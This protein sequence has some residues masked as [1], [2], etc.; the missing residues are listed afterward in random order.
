M[1][2]EGSHI[3]IAL[4]SVA[5]RGH[6]LN[7]PECVLAHRSGHLFA[8]D[9]SGAGG[10]AV[11]APDG[12]V[13]HL[14]AR[15]APEP[16]K[17]NGIALE[18]GGSFLIAHLGDTRGGVYRLHPDGR[19]EEV[20]SAVDGV[21]LP[22][23]NFVHLDPAGRLWIT[24]S[25]RQQPRHAAARRDVADGFIVLVPPGGAPR[26]VADGL[27]YTNEC[28]VSP[29]GRSLFVNET[30]SKRLSRYAITGEASLG[31]RETVATFGEG[32]FPDGLVPDMEGGLW[33]TSIV[34]NRVIRLAPDGTAHTLLE[35]CDPAAVAETE[36]IFE[37]GALSSARLGIR[38]GRV[39]ADISSL[40]FGGPDLRT[41]YLGCLKGEAIGTI[42][43][44]VAGVAP[45]HWQ[46]DLTPLADV[47]LVDAA[48]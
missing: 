2:K 41:G 18:P 4:S 23:S 31:P 20:V 12:T 39:L 10:V 30:F 25:T 7:R 13:R 22:P 36:A 37:R 8:A 34:S 11:I 17:P 42:A 48:A 19:V 14:V 6:G 35:D 26:I 24:I 21:P 38:H 27:G 16:M 46:T 43:M 47:G 3:V 15:D 29:D 28:I 45:T 9:W 40:A 44:P 1:R 33:I 32:T 5:F